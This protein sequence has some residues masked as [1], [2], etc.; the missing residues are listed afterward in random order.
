MI[1]IAK[2]L[3]MLKHMQKDFDYLCENNIL[4]TVP[5]VLLLIVFFKP[6]QYELFYKILLYLRRFQ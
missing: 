2:D 3:K 5:L 1:N 6:L 4:I